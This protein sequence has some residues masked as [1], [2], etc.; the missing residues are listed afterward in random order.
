MPSMPTI[1]HPTYSKAIDSSSHRPTKRFW[2]K[3]YHDAM[4]IVR[5][6]GKPDFFLTMTC[7]PR[8]PEIQGSLRPGESATDRPDLCAR[9]FFLKHQQ[10]KDD[11]IKKHVLGRVLAHVESVEHQKRGLPHTHLIFWVAAADKPTTQPIV[12]ATVSA[13][14]PDRTVNP[15]LYDMVKAHM[16]HGPCGPWNRRLVCMQRDNRP[17]DQHGKCAKLYPKTLREETWVVD[18]YYPDYRRRSPDHGG[19]FYNLTRSS[20]DAVTV[21]NRWVVPYNP[22]LYSNINAT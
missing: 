11:L 1:S 6:Y 10:L 22:R 8:W 7:N 16:I 3:C 19:H 15:E 4:A 12:D 2:K 14:L 13:K 5:F 9:V 17:A 20:G 18:D 21:D